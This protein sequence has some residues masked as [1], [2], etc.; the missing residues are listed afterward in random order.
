MSVQARFCYTSSM[1]CVVHKIT[2]CVL[3]L[4]AVRSGGVQPKQTINVDGGNRTL[5]PSCWESGQE[6]PCGNVKAALDGAELNNSTIVAVKQKYKNV[7]IIDAPDGTPCPTWFL[8]D[9]SNNGTCR[10]GSDIDGAVRCNDSTKE[11]A[12][13][14]Y[15]CM[16]Y[17]ESTGPVVGN[18]F[19]NHHTLEAA[20][21]HPLPSNITNLAITC[22]YYNRAGQLCGNCKKNYNIPVYSYDLTCVQCS[23]SYFSWV[24]YILA[25]FLP[26]T[27]FFILALSFRL[28][29]TSPRFSTFAFLSQTFAVGPNVRSTLAVIEPYPIS[30]MLARVMFSIYGI[31][32]LDFFRTLIPPICVSIDTLQVLAL[33]YALA[34]YPLILFVITYVLIQ[35]NT[36]NKIVI[37][38]MCRPF[39]RCAEHF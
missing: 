26:L 35:V 11:V 20:L 19:Y 14:N 17:N 16:T 4:T 39:H 37:T 8:R 23:T 18:C 24:K 32:N 15:Y 38:F 25:A 9:S 30:E 31:W 3:L 10:C 28:S 22:G 21:Y 29:A 7:P 13:L 6:S 1:A 34:F 33:D 36:F 5:G 12:I 2:I 27:I